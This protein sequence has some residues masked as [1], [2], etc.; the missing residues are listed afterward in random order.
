[1]RILRTLMLI[2]AAT[3]AMS[4]MTPAAHAVSVHPEPSGNC[5]TVT[6]APQGH[7][8]PTGGCRIFGA[9]TTRTEFGTSLGMILCDT[10]FEA[11]I[12]NNGVGYIYGHDI[13]NCTTSVVPCNESG[14]PDNWPIHLN[15]DAAMEVD[16]CVVVASFLTVNCHLPALIVDQISH[17][18]IEMQT[19]GHD[20]C[21]QS[22]TKSLQAHLLFTADENHP[23]IVIEH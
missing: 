15:A 19:Q 7:G 5:G 14:V 6:N 8:T 3:V 23:E 2:G 17:S 12:G 13:F 22:Q 10:E 4:L 9:S 11:T 16:F 21:E 20:F 18:E 1:M